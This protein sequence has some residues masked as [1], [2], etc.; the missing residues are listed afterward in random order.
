VSHSLGAT[1]ANHYLIRTNDR[2][3]GAWVFISILN[4]LEDM[5]RIQI[6]V[7]DIYAQRDWDV[8][9][10]GADERRRQIARVPGSEQMMVPGALHFF[11]GQREELTRV[12]VRFLDR[13]FV[14]R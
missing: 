10:T 7:L 1:M 9:I 2:K 11:E 3:V 6:P 14:A 4:G 12:I 5:F 8:I 13:A